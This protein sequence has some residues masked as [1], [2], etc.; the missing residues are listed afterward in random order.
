MMRKTVILS[1]AMMGIALSGCMGGGGQINRSME[2]VH[3][4]IVSQQNFTLDVNSDS[5]ELAPTDLRRVSE[6]LEAM[7]VRF[8]DR[9]SVD[10]SAAYSANAVHDTV[11]QL[12]RRRGMMLSENAPITP[13]AI[14]PG[15]VR[16]IISRAS[17]R[18]DGCPNWR[19]RSATDFQ[20]TV[21]SNYG[22]ATNANMAAMVADPLD[23]VRGQGDRANDP[24]TASRAIEGYRS[25]ASRSGGRLPA[26]AGTG[27]GGGGGGNAGSGGGGNTGGGGGNTG[28]GSSGGGSQ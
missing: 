6:W 2:S 3:Q 1:T 8:G 16:V 5:G 9:V 14:A 13:G 18:V 24:L 11:D 12:L 7:D 15:H 10:D 20:S 19:T 26:S 22:C 17:A 25:R 23:L 4:P 27:G 21:T 28:G